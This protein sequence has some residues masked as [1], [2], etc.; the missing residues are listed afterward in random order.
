MTVERLQMYKIIE[1][2]I[3]LYKRKYALPILGVDTTKPNVQSSRISDSTANS[4]IQRMNV[5]PYIKAEYKRLVAEKKELDDFI[6]GI[7]DE[8]IKAVAKR[9]FIEKETYAEMGRALNYSPKYLKN[10]L[11]KFLNE[12]CDAV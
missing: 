3:E 7:K 5:D 4:A 1:T 12:R 8:L 9:R 2:E 6:Y 11:T 10:I